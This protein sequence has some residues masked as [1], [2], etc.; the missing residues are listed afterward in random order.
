MSSLAFPADDFGRWLAPF[1]ADEI[2]R[3]QRGRRP[4]AFTDEQCRDL[5]E[6]LGTNSLHRARDFFAKL[7]ADGSVDS[8][9][10]ASHLNVGTPRNIPAA[11]TTP[12]K[13]IA[14]R[15]GLA[16]PWDE[17]VNAEDRTV[18]RDRNGI[19]ARMVAALEAE[20]RRRSPA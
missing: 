20:N 6:E 16:L 19:A 11:V 18:W 13:R 5:A 8:V 4:D 1:V 12:I 15:L 3:R 9:T 10:M 2:E 17:T 7:E 14:K